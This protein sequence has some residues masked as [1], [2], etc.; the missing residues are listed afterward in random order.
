[1]SNKTVAEK[2]F[3]RVTGKDTLA[4]DYVWATPDLVYVHDVLGPLTI[5]SLKKMGVRK[6]KYRGKIVFVS[7]HIFPPKDTE[8]AENI[9]MMKNFAS[10]NDIVHTGEGLGIEH[11]LLIENGTIQPGM[12]VVGGDSHTVTAGGVGAL[13]TGL[14]STDI[15]ATIALGRNWFRVPESIRVEL[16]G[17][18]GKYVTGKDVILKLLGEIGVDGANYKSLEFSGEGLSQFNL[19]E[20]LAIAN[21]T[22]EGG[23]KAGL[24]V[25]DDS[26]ARHYSDLGLNP[27]YVTPD[28]GAVYT[29]EVEMNLDVLTPQVA[30][31]FSPGNVKSAADMEG[32]RIDQAYLGNCA[33]GTITDLRQAASVL[34]NGNVKPGV[35]LIIVP[36][37]RKI[38]SQAIEEGLIKTFLDAGAVISPSTCGACAGLHLG[39]LGNGEVAISNTNRNYRGRMGHPGSKVYLSNSYVVAA[40]AVEGKIVNP[41]DSL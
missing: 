31:P 18:K 8:S 3:S 13:G 41:E 2:I 22:V 24:V 32:T 4:G 14:G 40:S 37:T 28:D 35:K 33:N 7:D 12:L 6:V 38:Y 39:I 20:R 16:K 1:M 23:A 27:D 34:R 26:I 15:A 36:A 30:V 29:G 17:R 21:M 5:Q 19:D 9:L 10:E 25:P 11:T